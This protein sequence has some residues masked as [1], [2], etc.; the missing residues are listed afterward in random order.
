MTRLD[1]FVWISCNVSSFGKRIRRT[2]REDVPVENRWCCPIIWATALSHCPPFCFLCSVKVVIVHQHF[3]TPEEGGALR[4]YYLAKAL[5]DAGIDTV[6]ITRHNQPAYRCVDVEGITVHYLPVVYHNHFGFSQRSRA[7][8]QFMSGAMSR[9]S[10]LRDADVVYAIS[11]PLT[12]GLVGL[13]ARWRYRMPYIFE[14]GDLWPEA[15]IQLGFVK[16]AV[17]KQLLYAF[18]RYVYRHADAVV[19]LSPMIRDAIAKKVPGVPLHVIPNMADTA[20]YQPVSKEAGLEAQ[21]GVAGKLVVSYIG[22][23]GYANGLDYFLECARVSQRAGLPV[24]FMLCGEGA[25]LESLTRIAEQQQLSNL[26]ILPFQ[27]R[28][29]VK[30][31]L[32]VTDAVFICYKTVPVLETGSPNKY[33]DGLAA[34]KLVIINFGGWIKDDITRAGCGIYVNPAQ[35]ASFV[36]AITPYIQSPTRLQGAQQA[37]R[38]LAEQQYARTALSQR[39]AAIFSRYKKL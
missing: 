13:W 20:Y 9:L 15:P 18:E 12:V 7:F 38:Q 8:L 17:F 32:S 3:H 31:L 26:T 1:R 28:D 4:S 36:E 2:R 24:H 33:F 5:V 30:Q 16:S 19:A 27:N 6:V 11:V 23:I 21:Y 35:P 22:A 10:S 29:G 14:V 37:S 25:R 34:G 39:F